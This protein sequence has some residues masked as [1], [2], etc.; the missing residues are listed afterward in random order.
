MISDSFSLQE[1]VEAVKGK[2]ADEIIRLAQRDIAEAERISFGVK[3][4]VKA[5]ER[6][7]MDYAGQLGGLVFWLERGHLTATKPDGVSRADFRA[8]RP[9]MDALIARG[10]LP[11]EALDQFRKALQNA[12]DTP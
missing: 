11:P 1:F 10:E 6:G 7:S 8:F 4:A 5:R 3:G 12:P 2:G 9:I